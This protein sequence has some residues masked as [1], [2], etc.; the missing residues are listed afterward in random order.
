M[1]KYKM[2]QKSRIHP[3][4]V[5]MINT[6]VRKKKD[7]KFVN[8]PIAFLRNKYENS[9]NKKINNRYNK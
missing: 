6:S 9:L 2:F 7:I 5:H 4:D 8:S 1:T 3:L